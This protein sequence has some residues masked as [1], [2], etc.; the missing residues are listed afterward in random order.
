MKCIYTSSPTQKD[1]F[2][3]EHKE[4][5]KKQEHIYKDKRR[6][7]CAQRLQVTGD[8]LENR[9]SIESEQESLQEKQKNSRHSKRNGVWNRTDSEIIE[10]QQR[11]NE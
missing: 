11:I 7:D 6:K 3:K 1:W 2:C 5:K 8:S 9:R 4:T 10:L